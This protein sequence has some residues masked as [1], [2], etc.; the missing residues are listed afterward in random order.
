MKTKTLKVTAE[1]KKLF[2]DGGNAK[3]AVSLTIEGVFV[4][5]GARL[6]EGKNGLFVS[7]PSRRN[8]DGEYFDVCFPINNETRLLI[9]GAVTAAYEKALSEQNAA[10]DDGGDG[11]ADGGDRETA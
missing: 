7:M 11:E 3:A 2:N 6:V 5:R 10:A 8:A 1:I 9:L 4:V